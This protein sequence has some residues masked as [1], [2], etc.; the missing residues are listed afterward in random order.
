MTSWDKQM[1]KQGTAG[2][3]K[4]VTLISQTLEIIRR[5]KRGKSQRA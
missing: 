5:L 4:Y 1:R 3:R 2:K